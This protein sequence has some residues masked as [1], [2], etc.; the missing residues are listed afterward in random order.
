I[1]MVELAVYGVGLSGK[2]IDLSMGCR[3]QGENDRDG[4]IVVMAGKV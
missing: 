2:V 1:A 4:G 3:G